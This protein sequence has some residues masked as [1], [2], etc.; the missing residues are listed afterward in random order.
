[1]LYNAVPLSAKRAAVE[2]QMKIDRF[3]EELPLI[4]REMK[5]FISFYKD[6]VILAIDK[7]IAEFHASLTGTVCPYMPEVVIHISWKLVIPAELV[8]LEA[9]AIHRP[10]NISYL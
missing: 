2:K 7:K 3:K 8:L 5:S 6:R 1:M 10:C 9:V 4:K